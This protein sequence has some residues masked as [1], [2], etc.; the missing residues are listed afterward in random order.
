MTELTLCI[1][2]ITSLIQIWLLFCLYRR[3]DA[4][5]AKR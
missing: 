3:V 5:E 4:M 1:L 2:A